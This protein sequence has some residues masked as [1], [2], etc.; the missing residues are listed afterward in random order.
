MAWQISNRLEATKTSD[1]PVVDAQMRQQIEAEFPKY[2]TKQAVLLTALHMV[3]DKYRHVSDQAILELAEIIE[4]S[5]AEVLD[6]L[7][8]Y[9]MYTREP[10]GEHKIGVCVSLSCEL[11]GCKDI[12]GQVKDKLG[13]GPGETTEDGKFSVVAMECIGACEFAP[14][15]LLDETV[16]KI[17][18]ES[19]LSQ[20]IDS[21]K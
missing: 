21:S 16:H 10:Q 18:S 9:D 19:Q 8:F 12:I 20:I 2:P 7:S 14:A 15:I 1:Q 11:C 4:I 6:T 5:P 17:D 13:I 3:Q